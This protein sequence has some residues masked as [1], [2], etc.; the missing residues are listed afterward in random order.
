MKQTATCRFCAEPLS[1]SLLNLGSSPLANAYLEAQHLQQGEVFFPLHPYVCQHCFLVQIEA[2]ATPEAIFSDY[3]YFS[4]FSE[5]W[6]RHSQQY[7]AD[8]LKFKPLNTQSQVIEL[9]SNDGYLLQYFLPH[10]IPVLGIEPAQN[11]AQAALDKGIPTW[12]CFFNRETAARVIAEHKQADLVIANNVLAHVPDLNGFVSA[13][14]MILKP[15]GMLTAEFPSLQNLIQSCQF[16]TIYHEHFSYF[17][18]AVMQKVLQHNGLQLFHVEELET[19]GG[20]LRIYACPSAEARPP[21]QAMHKLLAAEQAFGLQQMATYAD[22][23][24]AAQQIRLDILSLLLKLKR[25]G[26]QV[27]GYG[28]PAKGNT[29]LNYCGINAELLTYT[30]DRSPHKQGKFLPG[31]QIP[32]LHPDQ[33]QATQPDYV[34]IL[35]WNLRAEIMSQ[36]HFIGDWGGKFITAIPEVQIHA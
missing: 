20:S 33:I 34:L 36:L 23:F 1:F 15:D 12:S 29:F 14:A 21:S 19:H 7:V 3:D 11:V 10:Q 30:V 27:V 6:L 9:A 16:D 4:S 22:F 8:I 5:Q 31:S 13:I 28:A 24:Q 26:K 35:P 32:I 17:S 18:L 25:A 2:L